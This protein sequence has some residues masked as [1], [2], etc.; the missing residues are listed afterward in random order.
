MR[1]TRIPGQKEKKGETRE[2]ENRENSENGLLS[3][4]LKR[5]EPEQKKRADPKSQAP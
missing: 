5:G 4:F 3:L 1:S 2:R